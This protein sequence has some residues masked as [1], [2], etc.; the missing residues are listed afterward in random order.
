[1]SMQ[2]RI[3]P[4]PVSQ[5]SLSSGR[6]RGR[7][8]RLGVA[9]LVLAA[10]CGWA[11]TA[12]WLAHQQMLQPARGKTILS[13]GGA[14]F[15]GVKTC[16]RCHTLVPN[17]LAGSVHYQFQAQALGV[18]GFETNLLGL[19]TEFSGLHGTV[20]GINWLELLQSRDAAK[21]PQASGCGTCHAGTGTPPKPLP[22][23]TQ[24]DL[25]ELDC[26]I[27]HAPDYRRVVVRTNSEYRMVPAPEVDMVKAVQNVQR[28][29]SDMCLRCHA[30]AGGGPNFSHGVVPSE[31]TDVHLARG[32]QCVDCHT[33]LGHHVSGSGDLK[34]VDRPG[35][36]VDCARCHTEAPHSGSEGIY[37]THAKRVACQTC[38]IPLVA[39]S[40]SAPAV[41]ERDFTR[42][43]LDAQTGLFGPFTVT[44]SD[45]EPLYR[46]WNGKTQRYPNQPLGSLEDAGARIYPWHKVVV[47]V[48]AD[49]VE[50]SRRLPLK[51][52]VYKVQGSV[53]E[54]VA[55][56]AAE[57]GT[58][59]SGRWVRATDDLYFGLQHQVAPAAAALT[60][61]DCHTA[62]GGRLDFAALGYEPAQVSW[63][64]ST[65]PWQGGSHVGRFASG[66]EG[67]ASCTQC[68][69]GKMD[70]VA[71]SAHFTWRTP[72]AKIAH[73]GGGSHGMIDRFAAGGGATAMVNYYADP[74]TED[75][76][77]CGKCHVA[78]V[79]PVPNPVTGQFWQHQKEG[80]DCLICHAAPG[81]YDMNGDGIRDERDAYAVERTLTF[82]PVLG[83]EVWFQDRA[84]AA[85]ESVGGRVSVAA[86]QRC[87]ATG[88]AMAEANRGTPFTPDYDVHAAAGLQCTDCHKVA[89]HKIARGS[90]VAD[91]H[92]WERPDVE[93]DCVNCH[94]AKPHP[95]WPDN[96]ALVPYNEHYAYIACQTCHI[97]AVAGYTR[98][99]WTSIQGVTT[100]PEA[101]VPQ[102]NSLTG[103]YEPYTEY[104]PATGVRPV[105]RWFNGDAS[106]MAE[107]LHDV[108]A[109]DNA[110]AT[111][112]TQAAKIYP[113]RQ[114]VAG[115]V[116]DHRGQASAEGFDA[117]YT[118]AG[119]IDAFATP[120][121]GMGFLRAEGM[122]ARE[123]E[124]ASGMPNFLTFDHDHY[125]RT[126]DVRE[127]VNQGM[128]RMAMLMAGRNA[129]G[130]T[131]DS[132]SPAG[133]NLWSGEFM[134]LALPNNPA[135]P[136]Y[137]PLAAPNQ[138]TGGFI[139]LNHAVDRT[140]AYKCQDCHRENG[141]LDFQALSYTAEQ[142]TWLETMLDKVQFISVDQTAKGLRLR[143]A[144][145]P[146]RTYQLWST[147][148]P[149]SSAWTAVTPPRRTISRW[150]EHL[151]TLDAIKNSE[152]AFY[153][154]Q[155]T[156]P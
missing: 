91:L 155:E 143:W 57:S 126:G 4:N 151:V 122:T 37:N 56:G 47:A 18:E 94:T 45:V 128:G 15:E 12:A 116:L 38:H 39:R 127:A 90:R 142:A 121:T 100:G 24:K 136:T 25:D 14:N 106:M 66:F 51:E 65:A 59:Y 141:V 79:P 20:S 150:M 55:V 123:R 132:L 114:V 34:A 80:I 85:A 8:L 78:K 117:R 61:N 148:N 52:A 149:A 49:A 134:G 74:G 41:R 23:L 2:A 95:E 107:P 54:A 36:P 88:S 89:E 144:S 153:R 146:G 21:A 30:E 69:G 145:I 75:A 99:V 124:V 26:L 86:C 82:D 6:A 96:P 104:T 58:S 129:Y 147:A 70:E 133:S 17:D 98:R 102:Q 28:P 53:D 43:Q 29:T 125:A 118:L 42:P 72:N 19:V 97:P 77:S 103:L 31:F 64:A 13:G 156:Q 119:A 139:S 9:A 140:S 60:C 154:V 62:E 93:V 50:P 40:P 46:W 35:V 5:P 135:D 130:M 108:S 1:M 73:P 48:A 84:Q 111:R 63:L 76:L 83:R 112:V 16:A 11:E 71:A 32:M 109:W 120:L 7:R 131:P 137:D 92:A 3:A 67:A 110:V 87:H 10:S 101:S 81:Q 138:A 22:S 33:S 113:F 27:C 105:Y 68:H 44:E 152:G 115:P